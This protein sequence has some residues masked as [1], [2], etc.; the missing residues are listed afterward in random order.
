MQNTYVRGG[1]GYSILINKDMKVKIMLIADMHMINDQCGDMFISDWLKKQCNMKL[2]LEEVPPSNINLKELWSEADHT[3]KL[4]E[5][6]LNNLDKIVGLDIR[7]ELVKFSWELLK[8]MYFPPITLKEYLNDLESFFNLSHPFFKTNIPS[9]YN[10]TILTNKKL[11]IT[12]QYNY[13]F[14]EFNKYKRNNLDKMNITIQELYQK[15]KDN[16]EPINE[17][18]NSIMEFYTM[19]QVINCAANNINRFI[20]H[21]GLYHTSKLVKW[22]KKIYGFELVDQ[23][24]VTLYED[25]DKVEHNGCIKIPNL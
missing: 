17:L 3:Q 23:K 13:C 6:Y 19:M 1:I 25:V 8:D 4:R 10:N 7:G 9:I 18:L 20:I 15:N 22:L 11:E 14:E 24:G 21:K 16:L 12:K 5:L 2:L